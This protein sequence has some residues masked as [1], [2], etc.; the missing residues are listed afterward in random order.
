MS[1]LRVTLR[2]A[3]IKTFPAEINFPECYVVTAR[4]GSSFSK[5]K[6]DDGKATVLADD[7]KNGTLVMFAVNK[8]TY[9]Q[10]I[11]PSCVERNSDKDIK[12]IILNDDVP[13][14]QCDGKRIDFDRD[15]DD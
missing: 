6:A 11:P 13:R 3:P 8:D 7:V 10:V 12:F 14:V 4:V 15:D 5:I 9:F 1:R 2:N